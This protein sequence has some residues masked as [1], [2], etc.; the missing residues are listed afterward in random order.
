MLYYLPLP[1]ETPENTLAIIP[2]AK[3]FVTIN[4]NP[5]A[6]AFAEF[7]QFENLLFHHTDWPIGAKG[8]SD[9][10]AA[11][12]VRAAIE[13][14]FVRHCAITHCE[15]AHTGGYALW[16]D[17]GCQQNRITRNHLHELG[18]G[19]VRVGGSTE[20]VGT[21]SQDQ[22][23]A[24]RNLI[25]NNWLHDGGKIYHAAVGVWIGHG[26]YITVAN[27]EIS[28][29]YYTG[30]SNGWVWGYGDN[31][32]HHNIIEYNHIHH[33][34]KGLLSD[35]GGI[36]NLGIQPGS[37]L[38]NNHIHDVRSFQYGGWG[39]YT[40]EGSSEILLENNVVYNTT[41]GGFHQHY[42]K[43]NRIR[44]NIFAFADSEALIA[45]RIEEHRSFVFER[46]IVITRNGKVTSP[47]WPKADLW[48]DNNLFWD[49]ANTPLDFS[50][51]TLGAVMATGRELNSINTDPKCA[52]AEA[53]D[54]TLAPNSPAITQLGFIPIDLTRVGLQG[55]AEWINAPK[56]LE[57]LRKN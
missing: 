32:T 49:V 10:Q 28:D 11:N 4:G 19:G 48:S 27:N 14:K 41:S 35:M 7:I 15:V 36:Y 29:F 20:P 8:H 57:A 6:G 53:F 5:E 3:Q 47:N 26:N 46:N 25:D 45:S 40:D 55:E 51:T 54:F 38:R 18:A 31:P 2:S 30:V 24:S 50:G 16:L 43:N 44:N 17:A 13:L 42:G 34:G 1:G 12:S 21:M 23:V 37:V 22:V 39:L 56:A 33:I 9:P 52:N